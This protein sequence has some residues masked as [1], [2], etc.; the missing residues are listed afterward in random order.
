[1][2]PLRYA[3]DS[4]TVRLLARKLV[5]LREVS[6]FDAI[7]RIVAICAVGLVSAHLVGLSNGFSGTSG[8]C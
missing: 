2:A 5:P 7:W 8:G 1:M 3:H 4:L 6:G